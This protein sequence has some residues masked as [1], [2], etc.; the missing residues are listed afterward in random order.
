MMDWC[1]LCCT[2]SCD[3]LLIIQWLESYNSTASNVWF[4]IVLGDGDQVL[5]TTIKLC[6]GKHSLNDCVLKHIAFNYFALYFVLLRSVL[7]TS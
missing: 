1:I 5:Q 4:L 2:E 7:C 3:P 6:R